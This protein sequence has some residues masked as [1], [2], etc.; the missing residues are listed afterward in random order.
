[1]LGIP[2][3][4]DWMEDAQPTVFIVTSANLAGHPLIIDDKTADYELSSIADVIVSYNRHIVSRAD[5]SV[6]RI[7]E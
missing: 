6:I 4:C 5:D 3:G 2:E 1:M 7:A